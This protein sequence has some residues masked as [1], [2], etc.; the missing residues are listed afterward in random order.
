MATGIVQKHIYGGEIRINDS[1]REVWRKYGG[2]RKTT[3][4]IP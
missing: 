1:V 2:R 3:R 4:E